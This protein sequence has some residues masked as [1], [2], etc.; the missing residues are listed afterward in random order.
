MK[1][2]YSERAPKIYSSGD[3]R[4]MMLYLWDFDRFNAFSELIIAQAYSRVENNVSAE[5]QDTET[6]NDKIGRLRE[7]QEEL[8][9]PDSD[10]TPKTS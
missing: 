5:Y 7:R 10:Q 2:R 9:K 8:D 6:G 1:S 4:F 3:N